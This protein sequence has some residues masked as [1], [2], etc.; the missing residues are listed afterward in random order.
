[1]LALKIETEQGAS[2]L[3]VYHVPYNSPFVG[4][5]LRGDAHVL[6]S[7]GDPTPYLSE[8]SDADGPRETRCVGHGDEK[9][10]RGC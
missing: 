3:C 5:F 10:V 9:C 6:L 1:M 4:F 7:E 2:L 8:V